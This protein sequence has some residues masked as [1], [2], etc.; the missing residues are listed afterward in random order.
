MHALP[1]E[2]LARRLLHGH[3]IEHQITRHPGHIRLPGQ[4]HQAAGV[5]DG[6]HVA[7]GGGEIQPGG[8]ASEASPGALHG[9]DG[10]RGHQLGPLHPEQVGERHQ[11]MGNA[12]ALGVGLKAH[13]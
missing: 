5:G 12:V 3:S 4:G 11:E 8:E 7:I 2:H 10:A 13:D 9:R 1:L 6:E